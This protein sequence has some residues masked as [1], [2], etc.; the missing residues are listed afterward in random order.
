MKTDFFEFPMQLPHCCLFNITTFI[1]P[2]RI[3]SLES[4]SGI[5][6]V[7]TQRCMS[8]VVIQPAL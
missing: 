3:F 6:L 1:R 7:L 4:P 8:F 5:T 2:D